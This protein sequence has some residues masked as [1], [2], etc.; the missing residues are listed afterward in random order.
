[1]PHIL[2][3]C[4]ANICRSPVGEAFIRH[5]LDQEGLNSEKGWTVSSAGTWATQTRPAARFS[6]VELEKRNL[7]IPDHRA[8]M[9][10]HAMLAQADLALCMESHHVEALRA[11]FPRYADKIILF[12]EIAG[13][14]FNI[15]DPYGSIPE[16]YT[17][18]AL[19]LEKIL[20]DGW[21]TLKELAQTNAGRR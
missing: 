17:M 2:I 18:M 15:S 16:D 6:L 4:T 8:K 1:M 9:V 11:E 20:D 21:D 12:S 14:R 13:K 5:R 19:E 10:N 3:V 7:Q